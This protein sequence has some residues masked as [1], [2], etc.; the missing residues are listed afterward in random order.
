MK[1]LEDR[2]KSGKD[3]LFRLKKEYQRL[4]T[5]FDEDS[6]RLDL[7]RMQAIRIE[8]QKEHLQGLKLYNISI[9]LPKCI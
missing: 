5:D 9:L 3:G 7:L 4:S 8:K 2:T 6:R 1:Q